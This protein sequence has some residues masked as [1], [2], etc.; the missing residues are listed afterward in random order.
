MAYEPKSH[1]QFHIVVHSIW[2]AI[3]ILI[4]TT[5]YFTYYDV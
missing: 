1:T 2:V 4:G 5:T 3:A